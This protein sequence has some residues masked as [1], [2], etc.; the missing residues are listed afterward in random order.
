M[1]GLHVLTFGQLLASCINH[2]TDCVERDR[3]SLEIDLLVL[4]PQWR[5]KL[6][7][8]PYAHP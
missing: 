7:Q 8:R 2:L 1:H 4:G 6:H 3:E 5:R